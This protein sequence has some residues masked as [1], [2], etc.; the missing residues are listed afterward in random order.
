MKRQ[1]AT[2]SV[3]VEDVRQCGA[4]VSDRLL[5]ALDSGVAAYP[6]PRHPHMY[7]LE[8]GDECF[9]IAPLSDH[10]VALLAHWRQ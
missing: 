9:Y 5:A 3:T 7:I 8:W 1:V 2:I 4:E 10:K 6:D